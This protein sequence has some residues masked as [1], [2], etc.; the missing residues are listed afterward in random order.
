[1]ADPIMV[2]REEAMAAQPEKISETINAYDQLAD[3]YARLH[4]EFKFWKAEYEQFLSF[5]ERKGKLLDAGC[6][7]GRDAEYFSNH[8]FEVV[9]ID[10]S[11]KMLKKAKERNPKI[12]F[13]KMDMSE[14]DFPNDSFDNIWCHASFM[15]VPKVDAKK[16]LEGFY[17]V[18]RPRGMLF[19][20]V[21]HGKGEEM[22]AYPNGSR[23]F[24]AYYKRDEL[25]K[26]L[27]KA[28]FKVLEAHQK[29]EEA[30]DEWL[31]IIS[32]KE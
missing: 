32:I 16:V 23:I 22:K 1:M 28:N 9:G 26:L 11:E 12:Q 29:T 17:R 21:R 18:L 20:A 30:G 27:K 6:G 8:G 31:I 3:L 5:V 24:F 19:I 10:L 13:K 25:E 2:I 4:V 14:L 15:H 7:P